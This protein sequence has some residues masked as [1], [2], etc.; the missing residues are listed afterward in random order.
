MSQV[1]ERFYKEVMRAF[2]KPVPR[3]DSY[4]SADFPHYHVFVT[5]QRARPGATKKI[6]KANAKNIAAVSDAEV[7]GLSL[8]HY[9]QKG[10]DLSPTG[11]KT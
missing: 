4:D 9:M 11:K 3:T 1:R 2:G 8:Y 7:M 6:V 10:V 5:M